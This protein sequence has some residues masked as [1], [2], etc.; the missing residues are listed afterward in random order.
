[1]TE[2]KTDSKFEKAQS[3]YATFLDGISSLMLATCDASGQPNAS[4]AP[5]V[6]D[7]ERNFYV[8]ISGLSTHTKN[9]A[10]T[11]KVS[12]MAIEDEATTQQIFARG[13]L[14]FECS[15]AE[16]ERET[17][18][19]EAIADRFHKRFGK[20]IDVFRPL[21]DFR[22]IKLEPSAGRF[23]IGFGAAYDVSGDDLNTLVQV[24]GEGKGHGSR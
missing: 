23:V 16:L 11:G 8:Y 5:F 4:Y 10:E 13:R 22:I 1:M 21:P 19:W 14:S 24:T 15:A 20:I 9:I 7:D 17:E 18:E 12:V 3:T 6:A 2:S